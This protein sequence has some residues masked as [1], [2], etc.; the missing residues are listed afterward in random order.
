MTSLFGN[1]ILE[2]HFLSI[3]L[4]DRNVPVGTAQAFALGTAFLTTR[5]MPPL[6]PR[7]RLGSDS[8]RPTFH[9]IQRRSPTTQEANS[10]QI[11][12]RQKLP[13]HE[14]SDEQLSLARRCLHTVLP[15]K[16]LTA[17]FFLY[18]FPSHSDPCTW[19]SSMPRMVLPPRASA[20]T[21]PV[22]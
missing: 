19:L 22:V 3:R 5:G 13:A 20:H 9:C 15:V 4:K 8:G 11:R 16:L 6:P 17:P 1:E 18:E 2:R 7:H 12:S 14:V 10:T 21:A